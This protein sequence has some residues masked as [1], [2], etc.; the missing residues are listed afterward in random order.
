MGDKPHV[1]IIGAGLA[2]LAAARELRER[3]YPVVVLE[4]RSRIGGR[5]HTQDGIDLGAHWIHGTEGNPITTLA[6]ELNIDTQFVG[7]D[8]TYTGGWSPLMLYAQPHVALPDQDKLQH[9]LWADHLWDSLDAL[10][11]KHGESDDLPLSDAIRRALEG[12]AL[13]DA[14]RAALDWHLA[15]LARDDCAT[16]LDKL[17]FLWWDDGFEV[18]GYGDSVING[19]YGA[20]A[21]ALARDLDIRLEHVVQSIHYSATESPRVRVVTDRGTVTGDYVIVTVP[22][23]VLKA[24]AIRFEPPLPDAKQTA[25][26]R[27]GMGNLTK[28]VAVFDEPFWSRDQYVFGYGCRP[29]RDYPSVIINFWKSSRI[30]ALGMLIGGQRGTDI[31]TWSDD[32]VRAWVMQVLGDV[33]EQVPAPRQIVRTT[34]GHDPFAYGA[35]SYIGCGATPADMEALAEPVAGCVLF[36]GEATYRHHWAVAHGALVSGLRE[37]VRITGDRSMLPPRYTTENRRWRN[38]TMRL[39]R[40]CNL[41]TRTTDQAEMQRRYDL[42]S[43]SDVFAT[44]PSAELRTLAA[45]FEPLRY[46]DGEVICRAG[47]QANSVYA[48]VAGEI[49]VLPPNGDK[50]TVQAGNVVGEYAMFGQHVRSATMIARGDC[51]LL[52]LDYERFER[53]LLAFPEASL[54]LLKHVIGELVQWDTIPNKR[55]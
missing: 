50:V 6:H 55:V 11:R 24:G 9:L 29:I 46:T 7:G 49:D 39:N 41:V 54:A 13:D 42:L 1:I 25:I 35:Y 31:E 2:G 38:M 23:G 10:R 51:E 3:A 18:Y 40:F 47:E 20:L 36:A 34:W 12:R 26:E 48:L 21:A 45:M 44:V 16:D 30:P 8:S 53:F 19:G 33:F 22:L 28:V 27:L 14:E 43:G 5:C 37:A 15:V 4:A 52:S 17:S 32:A